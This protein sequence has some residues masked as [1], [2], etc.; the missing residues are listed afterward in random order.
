MDLMMK[1]VLVM[2]DL[3]HPR[4][5]RVYGMVQESGNCALV[6]QYYERG[7]LASYIHSEE[8]VDTTYDV[9]RLRIALQV[10][11][12]LSVEAVAWHAVFSMYTLKLRYG[13]LRI[14]HGGLNMYCSYK[15]SIHW[16]VLLPCLLPSLFDALIVDCKQRARNTQHHKI[17]GPRSCGS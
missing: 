5:A 13:G 10:G 14:S 15:K 8:Y 11:C 3:R 1:E 17:T 6:M 2:K 7:S 9:H 16:V 12:K 4:V